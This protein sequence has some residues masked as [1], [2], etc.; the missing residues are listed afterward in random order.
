MIKRNN[1]KPILVTGSHRSGT[2]WT[3]QVMAKAKNVRYVHEPFNIGVNAHS[4]PIKN[5]FEFICE[6][7]SKKHQKDTKLY[8]ESFYKVF[9]KNNLLR[10]F[11]IKS[12]RD[13]IVLLKDLKYRN[14][15]RTLIKD[16]I[17]LLSVEWVYN[18]LNA[19]IVV[20]VR[21]P[22]AFVASLKIKD[23]QFDFHNFLNQPLLIKKYLSR[24]TK[25]IESFS[26]EQKNIIEQGILLWNILHDVILS[27]R[28]K[29][30]HSWCFAKH[31]ELSINPNKEF[32]K[33]F[34]KLNL[35]LD[36]EVENYIKETSQG[37]LS[38]EVLKQSTVV[39]DVRRNSKQNIKSWKERLTTQEI[40]QIKVG[41]EHIWK[42]FYSESD[43]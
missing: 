25:Q 41:T 30:D 5:M 22:A 38:K 35:D 13:F 32:S 2:T 7:S 33:I 26:S 15:N 6:E 43:W 34:T 4:G 3:G 36:N 21:H 9:H 14:D 23:W 17:A 16:P 12:L 18:H 40:N 42:N 10:L 8:L 24:Y 28:Q 39:S 19:D 37:P 29:Y 31:E 1:T 20:M 27:Y 11:K